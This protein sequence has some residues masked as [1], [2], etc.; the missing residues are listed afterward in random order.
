MSSLKFDRAFSHT[1]I[2]SFKWCKFQYYLKYI[3]NYAPLPSIGQIRGNV[4]HKAL[5]EWYRTKDGSRAY[6]VASEAISQYEELIRESLEEEWELLSVIIPRYFSWA[7]DNDNFKEVLAIEEKFELEL[8]GFRLIGYIDGIVRDQQNV[9]WLLEH[10]FLKRVSTGHLDLDPQVSL[11][12]YAARKMGYDVRGVLYNIIRVAKGG[13]AETEPVVR[14]PLYRNY[15]GLQVIEVELQRVLEEIYAFHQDP[16]PK[17]Y[18]NETE[19]CAWGCGFF[20]ACLSLND[21][22]EC[23]SVLKL[24]PKRIEELEVYPDMNSGVE[25]ND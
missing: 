19:K 6:A 13:K 5:G 23:E 21:S 11:Y 20:H 25:D 18:R 8:G 3:Q 22:G 9:L 14:V 16:E 12:I 2:S 7:L 1:S 24:L 4:G 17:L 15:E 10:K